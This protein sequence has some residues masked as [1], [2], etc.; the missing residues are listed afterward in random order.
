[1]SVKVRRFLWILVF[2]TGGIVGILWIL[3]N[4]W[5][6]WFLKADRGKA[7][8]RGLDARTYPGQRVTIQSVLAYSHEEAWKYACTSGFMHHV[9][10]PL[11]RMQKFD[12]T[13]PEE[14]SQGDTFQVR[15]STLGI[16]PLGEHT[17]HV[18]AVDREKGEIRSIESGRLIRALNHTIQVE[19]YGRNLTLYTD[20]VRIFAGLFTPFLAWGVRFFYRYRQ[21]RWQMSAR[22]YDD[23]GLSFGADKVDLTG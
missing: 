23:W 20:D 12:H 19:P 1:M 14:W 3:E 15:L 4:R 16:I 18:Q 13:M 10:W 17:I 21:S 2:V 6:Q 5:N 11:L 7:N 9:S 8:V 22:T